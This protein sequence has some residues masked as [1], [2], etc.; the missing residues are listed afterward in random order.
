MSLMDYM[1]GKLNVD[2]EGLVCKLRQI[3]SLQ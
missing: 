1:I 2:E 3:L